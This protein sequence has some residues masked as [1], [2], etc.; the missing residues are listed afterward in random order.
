MGEAFASPM[1]IQVAKGLTAQQQR[2]VLLHEVVHMIDF[3]NHTFP[4][5][6]EDQVTG[7]AQCLVLF[8]RDNPEFVTYLMEAK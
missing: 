5:L 3:F 6:R 8:F 2:I 7:L 4:E 1:R